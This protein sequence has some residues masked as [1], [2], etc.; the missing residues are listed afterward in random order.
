MSCWPCLKGRRFLAG[1]PVLRLHAPLCEAQL[2]EGYLRQ[3]ISYQTRVATQTAKL[4]AVAGERP[5]VDHGTRAHAVSEASLWGARASYIAG[6]AGTTYVE[7]GQQLGV[8]IHNSVSAQ[9]AASLGSSDA[10]LKLHAANFPVTPLARLDGPI[11]AELQRLG[12]TGVTPRAVVIGMQDAEARAREARALLDASSQTEVRI[13]AVGPFDAD[14]V[15]ALTT[16]DAPI[17][18]FFVEA[19]ADQPWI[20]A[21]FDLLEVQSADEPSHDM[22]GCPVAR[23]VYRRYRTDGTLD[24]DTLGL[25][26]EE[27]EG[28]QLIHPALNSGK[29]V[30]E[31]PGLETIR[32]HA[33]RARKTI[34]RDTLLGREACPPLEMSE[35]LAQARKPEG[36]Q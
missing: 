35:Q 31:R 25:E 24:R 11:E 15:E 2:V 17:H 7:A 28:T 16:A 14:T 32:K 19:G 30:F 13:H 5:V 1:E 29:L 4:V 21:H 34:G 22:T 8:P 12:E 3:Q 20:E 33:E 26:R 36:T 23:Q 18:S 27:I 6:G 10:A 9:F